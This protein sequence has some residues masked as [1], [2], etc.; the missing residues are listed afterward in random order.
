MSRHRH[1]LAREACVIEVIWVKGFF[2]FIVR[3]EGAFSLFHLL[4]V[5]LDEFFCE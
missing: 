1:V 5:L 2:F 3:P 4:N